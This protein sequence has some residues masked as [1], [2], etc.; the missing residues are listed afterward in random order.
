MRLL[1]IETSWCVHSYYTLCPY[2]PD[3]S[4]RILAADADLDTGLGCV[5]VLDSDGR[6][7]DRFGDGDIPPDAIAVGSPAKVVKSRK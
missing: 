4:A 3:G 5:Y 7:L 1:P 2:A 6:V